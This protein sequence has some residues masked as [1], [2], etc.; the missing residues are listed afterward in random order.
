VAC[1]P[2]VW[3]ARNRGIT[4]GRC[5]E[6]PLSRDERLRFQTELD[7]QGFDSR[8][9]GRPVWAARAQALANIRS[10]RPGGPDGFATER[11]CNCW[12]KTARAEGGRRVGK[13]QRPPAPFSSRPATPSKRAFWLAAS[14]SILRIAVALTRAM[15]DVVMAP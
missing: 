10:T 11:C 9:A 12:T 5:D 2:T 3:P 7:G 4:P 14:A 13:S 1:W 15:H 8:L 6:K